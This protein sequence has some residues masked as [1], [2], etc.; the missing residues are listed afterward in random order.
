MFYMVKFFFGDKQVEDITIDIIHHDDEGRH[1]DSYSMTENAPK[2]V[3]EIRVSVEGNFLKSEM[4]LKEKL[5][6][7]R[8]TPF[9]R[10][11]DIDIECEKVVES[12]LT[13]K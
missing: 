11:N 3:E 8:L 12:E 10:I 9:F 6:K 4:Y 1:I 5:V 2:E 7:V 13:Q